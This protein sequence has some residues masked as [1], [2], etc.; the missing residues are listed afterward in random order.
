MRVLLGVILNVVCS[1]F[2]LGLGHSVNIKFLRYARNGDVQK[3]RRAVLEH[4]IGVIDLD[5]ALAAAAAHSK[6]HAMAFLID[7]GA[8][9][10]DRALLSAA[11]RDHVGAVKFLISSDRYVPASNLKEARNLASTTSAIN[12]EWVLVT[13][14]TDK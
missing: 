5:A 2:A 4:P 10:L 13:H 3:L 8:A 11:M 7:C 9:D 12:A 1:A 14:S 6:I